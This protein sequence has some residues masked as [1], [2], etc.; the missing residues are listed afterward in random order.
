MADQKTGTREEWLAARKALLVREK[1]LTRQGDR[2]AAE[3]RD[4][5]WLAI[6]KEYRFDTDSGP[7]TLP[8]L[9]DGRSQLIVYHFMFG[10]DY[11]AGCPA[12]SSIA[13]GFNGSVPHLNA[14]DVTFT[15][16]S[17][18]PLGKLR[19]YRARM[20]WSFPWASSYSSDYNFDLEISHPEET[21]REW[22]AG[23]VPPVAAEFAEECGTSPVAY[24]SESPVL[25]SY[26]LQDGNVYLTYSTTARGLE[27][28]MVYYSLLDRVPRGRDEADE[29][30]LWLRRHDEYD[31]Q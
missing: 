13:D 31:S 16:I 6:D 29:G 5:P 21:T 15:A 10:P 24:L 28:M 3:R 4:L 26:A 25:N 8:E 1:E 17:R 9:F 19:T 11:A 14:R 18:A 2:L 7:K 22:L 12:C 23:G 20:G 30:Q 27:F